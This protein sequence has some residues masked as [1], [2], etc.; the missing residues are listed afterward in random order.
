MEFTHQELARL[1]LAPDVDPLWEAALSLHLLQNRSAP[2]TF[3]PWRREVSA[4]LRVAGLVPATR[5]LMRLCPDRSYFPDFLTPG[6]GDTDLDAGLERLLSTPR[7]RLR[8]ELT[9]LY[10]HTGH[11][12][13]TAVRPLA[14][15]CPR[16][17]RRLGSALRAYHRVAVEPYLG[18]I[19]AQA[20][21][22]RTARAEAVLA[23]GAEGLLL[24]YDELPGWRYR[25]RT[26]SAPYPKDRELALRGRTLT[27]LPAFFCVRSPITLAD[28]ELPPVL[29]HP[30]SPA[31]GWLERRHPGG[32]A[33]AAQLIGASRAELLRI[34]DRPMTTMDLA[35]ALR[36]A[37]STASRHAT[38]LREAGLLLS[39]RQGVRVLH[40]RTRLGRAV[41]EGAL[42]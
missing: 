23:H 14:D 22:D 15:G 6:R 5:T 18:A 35:A 8:A 32:G 1:R 10:A 41:L 16:A 20:E 3:D 12:V 34:L 9:R 25:D 2:L 33:P 7:P 27:L 36:L 38:V 31:P 11:P 17:L 13:P 30:L 24:G 19:R 21:A 29:V 37:P 42:R 28:E 39:Q 26:L 4:A 40:H